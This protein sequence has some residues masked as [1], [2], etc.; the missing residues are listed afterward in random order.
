MGMPRYREEER[1]E[2]A[3]WLLQNRGCLD[4]DALLR[5]YE[6][7][8]E[9]YEEQ[10][11][12]DLAY[13]CLVQ[14]KQVVDALGDYHAKGRYYDLL[15]GYHDMKL[16]GR[17]GEF[18]R[19]SRRIFGLLMK[20]LNR[21][22]FCMKRSGKQEASSLLAEYLRCKANL[23]IRRTPR[24]KGRIRRLLEKVGNTV[25]QGNLEYTKLGMALALTLAWYD[26]YV[27]PDEERTKACIR[28]AYDVESAICENDLD[29]VDEFLV[30][31]ANVMLEW[32]DVEEAER[33]LLVGVKLCQEQEEILPF[34]RKKQEL[35]RYLLDVYSIA[36]E[37]EKWKELQCLLM[38]QESDSG[39][40]LQ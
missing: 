4:G 11:Q 5:L 16:A 26:T 37:E 7:V 12:L 15:V 21:A 28:L 3:S 2:Y 18:D 24:E 33:L 22:I 6:L 9:I 34:L 39:T 17:Y 23:L 35:Q 10:G 30:P 19:E 29:F 25:Q 20:N 40:T 1:L 38:E 31:G 32:G 14:G 36:G 13:E 8:S 27:E